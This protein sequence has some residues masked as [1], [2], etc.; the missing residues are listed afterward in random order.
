MNW[1]AKAAL[2]ALKTAA[3]PALEKFGEAIGAAVGKRVVR[4]ADQNAPS[5]ETKPT[6]KKPVVDATEEALTS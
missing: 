2:F 6:D 1:Y 3:K 5:T 4:K